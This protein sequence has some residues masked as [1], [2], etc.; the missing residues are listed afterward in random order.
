M[1]IP[2]SFEVTE[3]EILH[4]LIETES[5]GIL[6]GVHDDAPYA[7]HIPFLLDRDRGPHGTLIA[8]LARNNPQ[9]AM[10][11]GAQQL[12]AVFQ[13]PH[14]YISPR[15][16]NPGNAVPTWN[17]AVVHAY[18]A[19]HIITDPGDIREQ[20]D[21]L[22]AAYEG[23]DGWRMD[24]QPADYIDGM[25]DGITAFEMPLTRLEGKF[26]LS[27]NRSPADQMSVIARLRQSERPGDTALANLMEFHLGK[28]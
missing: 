25:L 6:V 28:D 15:W 10:F 5:F 21:R 2:N 27:Q 7:S 11:D 8:H 22:V 12:L 1:F 4:D 20:Q 16:Y 9:G 26:K 14:G 3:A 23:T 17:Y 19:A 13:G 18:G 24:C